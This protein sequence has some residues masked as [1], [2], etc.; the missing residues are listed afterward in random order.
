M[1]KQTRSKIA[2][3]VLVLAF[4][5]ISVYI[6]LAGT[7]FVGTP[8]VL[9]QSVHVVAQRMMSWRPCIKKT[10]AEDEK[11]APSPCSSDDVM[12]VIQIEQ[13]PGRYTA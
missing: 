5:I 3:V 10:E 4:C 8:P 6:T 12:R 11:L 2:E 9:I 13:S 1:T 7:V